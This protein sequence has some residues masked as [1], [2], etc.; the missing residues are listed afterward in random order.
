MAKQIAQILRT[1][2]TPMSKLLRA[3]SIEVREK[4]EYGTLIVM[5]VG[6]MQYYLL[7]SDEN[8][9]ILVDGLN[10]QKG[11]KGKKGKDLDK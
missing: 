9:G 5:F 2:G 8:I 10:A 3:E 7:L 1:I 4:T 11:K 6:N